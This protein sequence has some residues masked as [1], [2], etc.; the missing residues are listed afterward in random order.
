LFPFLFPSM[1]YYNGL[2]TY[3]IRIETI[4]TSNLTSDI[5]VL[6]T[7]NFK[8]SNSAG[9]VSYTSDVWSRNDLSVFMAM[10]AHYMF[11]DVNGQLYLQNRLV[12]FRNLQGSHTGDLRQ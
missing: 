8:N 6:L 7:M 4:H 3:V 12:A 11:T 1:R 9:R 10:T 2:R 5:C